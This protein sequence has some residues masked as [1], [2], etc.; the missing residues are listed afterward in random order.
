MVHVKHRTR[1]EPKIIMK[2]E[3]RYRTRKG[4]RRVARKTPGGRTV[5]HYEKKAPGKPKCAI[6][7]NYLHGVPR[8]RP[9]KMQKL[10]RTQRTVQRP[11][12]AYLC[13]SCMRKIIKL[14]T[15]LKYGLIKK[16]SIPLTLRDYVI[17]G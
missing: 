3:P 5:I 11:F 8:L 13:S 4:L 10:N 7:K 9:K 12:G 15:D 1:G 14:R 17:G 16:E 2:G 6:C